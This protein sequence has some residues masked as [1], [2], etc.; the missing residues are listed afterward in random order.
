MTPEQRSLRSYA[1]YET[2]KIKYA[3]LKKKRYIDET[4][5]YRFKWIPATDLTTQ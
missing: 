4:G 3:G 1:G 2:Q 5:K